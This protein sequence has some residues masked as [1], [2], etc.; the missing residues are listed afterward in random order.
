VRV[1]PPAV[2]L[3]GGKDLRLVPSLLAQAPPDGF[4]DDRGPRRAVHRR[5][6]PVALA[7]LPRGPAPREDPRRGGRGGGSGHA[8]LRSRP[9]F[10][11]IALQGTPP[12]PRGE[13]RPG[14]A[15]PGNPRQR[16][17]T[18]ECARRRILRPGTP[19]RFRRADRTELRPSTA[20]RGDPLFQWRRRTGGLLQRAGSHLQP[21]RAGPGRAL[22][23]VHQRHAR[24]RR[25]CAA[26]S[27]GDTARRTVLPE[28]R[29]GG[30]PEGARRRYRP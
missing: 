17:R 2:R 22:F 3:P 27:H 1:A 26:R 4:R 20:S 19:V 18:R 9:H 11:C 14:R 15:S 5:P 8:F 28:P 6:W 7:P 13:P 25:R 23:R 21:P 12:R 16:Q 24:P 30:L 10:P 29:P